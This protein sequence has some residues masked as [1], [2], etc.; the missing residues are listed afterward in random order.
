[1]INLIK[2]L[3]YRMINNKTFLIMPLIITPIVIAAAIYFSSSFVTRANI[4]VVGDYNVNLKSDEINIVKLEKKVPISDLVKNKYE[5]VISFE[6]GKVQI[7]TIKGEDFK[8]RIEKILQ[9]ERVNFKEGERRGIASNIVGF[10]TMFVLLLGV[11]L[12]RFFF[13]DKKG[14]SK[15]II[16][17]NISYEQYVCSHFVSVFIMIF[18]PTALITVIAKELLNLDTRINA[19]EFIFII[20]ILSLLSSAFGLLMS[21]IVK[22]M[23]SASMLGVMINML[24]TLLAGSFF[25]I[26]NN[27]LIE[28]LGSVFPQKHI[29]DFTVFLENGKGVS[30]GDLANVLLVTLMMI[31]CSFLINKYKMRRYNCM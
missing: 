14:I 4:G 31:I 19:V 17:A 22:E 6:N 29:L 30:Y 9:G 5:A 16:S 26:S 11:M 12:Y 10:I 1:M 28:S 24:T 13:D 3:L 21:S 2:G 15:R 20:L 27:K 7:D 23:E 8:N 25:T 18:I